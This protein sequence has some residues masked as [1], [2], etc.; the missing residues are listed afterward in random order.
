MYSW[1]NRKM[2]Y[3][4]ILLFCGIILQLAISMP[5]YAL[6]QS[7]D[8]KS[9]K[10]EFRKLYIAIQNNLN[11]EKQDAILE[12]GKVKLTT[13]SG[14]EYG[15]K[16]FED[17]LFHEYQNS[18]IKV[19]KVYQ[20]SKKINEKAPNTNDTLVAFF[21]GIDEKTPVE[22]KKLDE[23]LSELKKESTVAN[24]SLK[25]KQFVINDNDLYLLKQL[26]IHAQDKVCTVEKYN[27]KSIKNDKYE[28]IKNSPL[29]K[30][31]DA[32]Q[33]AKITADSDLRLVNTDS[34]IK[35]AVTKQMENLRNWMRKLN[36]ENPEC[37]KEVKENNDY[38]Q[39]DMQSCN[40]K[41]FI[42]SLI[43]DNSSVANLESILHFINAN[44]AHKNVIP[45]A[46]TGIDLAKL[47][48]FINQTFNDLKDAV[49]CS[50]VDGDSTK[51]L[52][53]RNLPYSNNKLDR[54][55]FKCKIGNKEVESKECDNGMEFVSDE[56]G[57]GFEVKK[58]AGSKVSSFSVEGDSPTCK[59]KEF[60]VW[61][62][63]KKVIAKEDGVSAAPATMD[64]TKSIATSVPADLAKPSESLVPLAAN[65]PKASAVPSDSTNPATIVAPSDSVKPIPT[66]VVSDSNRPTASAIPS[67]S[68]RPSSFL[69]L[70]VD[71]NKSATPSTSQSKHQGAF[72][73]TDDEKLNDELKAAKKCDNNYCVSI[74][75][76]KSNDES[77]KWE[78]DPGYCYSLKIPHAPLIIDPSKRKILCSILGKDASDPE[79][80][81][82][83]GKETEASCKAKTPS[84]KFD[85]KKNECIAEALD[86]ESKCKEKIEN[87]VDPEDDRPLNNWSWDSAKKVCVEKGKKDKPDRDEKDTSDG[88]KAP[89]VYPNKSPP[90]RFIPIQAPI[91]QCYPYPGY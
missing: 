56:L 68:N 17:A 10:A 16:L 82:K 13:H 36:A 75:F 49:V 11:Y 53:I 29:N 79:S 27:K 87:D 43:A 19:A 1:D 8:C 33:K 45:K 30:M 69:S 78:A 66:T 51:K 62:D 12:G 59:D 18:L 89:T 64:A 50:E 57:R 24:S 48:N 63:D 71:T 39:Y 20:S 6:T 73:R 70:S 74:A 31:L 7:N 34:V 38:V 9:S 47:D 15:G 41:K 84:L 2:N 54:S 3:K 86:D 26:L 72:F 40:Y 65:I 21:K 61:Y 32:L 90:G 5:L 23:L 58:K 55:K 37:Y 83:S 46:E 14:E 52:F 85:E 76:N 80:P 81:N 44:Q 35:S 22:Y 60:P 67:D 28:K 4:Q 77:I 88:E 91:R 25:D 42:N